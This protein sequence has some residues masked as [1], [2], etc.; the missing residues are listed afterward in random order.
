[1]ILQTDSCGGGNI[2]ASLDSTMTLVDALESMRRSI[3]Q[4]LISTVVV[5]SDLP[6]LKRY[7]LVNLSSLLFCVVADILYH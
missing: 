1:M 3:L 2:S 4:S 6:I 7:A 5:G